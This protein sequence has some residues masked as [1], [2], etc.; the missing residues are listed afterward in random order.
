LR[1]AFWGCLMFFLGVAA[2]A[3]GVWWYSKH[4]G[5]Q[6]LSKQVQKITEEVQKLPGTVIGRV[7]Q[8]AP[9][10]APAGGPAPMPAQ[11]PPFE[12]LEEAIGRRPEESD[13]RDFLLEMTRVLAKSLELRATKLSDL[14]YDRATKVL[15]VELALTRLDAPAA[16][17]EKKTTFRELHAR[18][19]IAAM[20][21][22]YG[23]YPQGVLL[24]NLKSFLAAE[25]SEAAA[26]PVFECHCSQF[27]YK[28]IDPAT[29][30]WDQTMSEFH[31]NYLPAFPG[32]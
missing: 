3:V 25:G 5:A 26:K 28:K 9:A 6:E 10:S 14:H 32:N 20:R 21:A 27:T 8:S 11:K 1:K 13:T 30:P 7:T 2:C 19:V 12:A 16:E 31:A 22:I 15:K 17:G 18:D 24:V 4:Y 29:A 23:H